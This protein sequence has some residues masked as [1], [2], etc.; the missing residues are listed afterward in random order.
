MF[1]TNC[2]MSNEND[3]RFCVNCAESLIDVQ[4]EEIRSYARV[5][6]NTSVLR[7]VNFLQALFDFSFSQFISPRIIKFLYSLSMIL[8]CLMALFL[9]IIGFETSM[10]F[11]IFSLLIGAPLLFLLTVI[12]NRVVLELILVIY[13]MAD[14][15]ENIRLVDMEERPESRDGIQWNV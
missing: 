5:F 12:S 15:M 10:W 6:K 7:K 14:S 2:G 13:R 8:A 4:I 9:I 1:C 3:A 11:G